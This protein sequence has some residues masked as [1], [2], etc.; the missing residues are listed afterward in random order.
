MYIILFLLIEL[1]E[2]KITTNGILFVFY[3]ANKDPSSI[4]QPFNNTE[5]NVVCKI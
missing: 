3:K 2:M 4:L 1:S 5:I